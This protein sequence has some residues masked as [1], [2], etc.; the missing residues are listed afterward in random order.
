MPYPIE[1]NAPEYVFRC[2]HSPVCDVLADVHGLECEA[3]NQEAREEFYSDLAAPEVARTVLDM[4]TDIDM[5][6]AAAMRDRR[7][8]RARRGIVGTVLAVAV[9]ALTG[10]GPTLSCH[11]EVA[12]DGGADLTVCQSFPAVFP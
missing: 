3:V 6:A 5:H 7:L 11:V 4:M 2:I 9:L 10:C 8:S 12:T 1:E